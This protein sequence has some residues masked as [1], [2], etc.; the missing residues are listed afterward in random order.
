MKI[1]KKSRND[2]REYLEIRLETP[3]E[4]HCQARI[5]FQLSIATMKHNLS[6]NEQHVKGD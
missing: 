4:S 2:H 3:V 6:H 1:L 5:S